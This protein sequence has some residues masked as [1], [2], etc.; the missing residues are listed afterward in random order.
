MDLASALSDR[1]T[2][3]AFQLQFASYR[4]YTFLSGEQN[5]CRDG[6]FLHQKEI[7]QEIDCF[8][9]KHPLDG[10]TVFYL[11]GAGLGHHYRALRAWLH[12]SP[13][14][15]LVIL[16]EDLA[17]IALLMEHSPDLLE[18]SQVLLELF[19][20]D[21]QIDGWIAQ[22]PT[23]RIAV[24]AIA[25]LEGKRFYALRLQILRKAAVAQALMTEALHAHKLLPN[26]LRNIARWPGSFFA[27]DLKGKFRGI[28][29]LI[30]G[31]GPS[32]EA[33]LPLLK[34]LEERA[35]L[36][37][38]GSTL[39]ALTNRGV[40]PHFGLAVDPNKEEFDRLKSASAYEVPLIY[41]SRLQP[42]VLDACSGE[43][44]YLVT[45]TGGPCETYFEKE[46]GIDQVA[47]GPE[48]GTEALSITTLAI[49]FAVE[50]GC[51]PILLC[52]IDLAYTGLRR[53]SGGVMPSSEID[54]HEVKGEV[55][56]PERHL[57]RKDIR[58]KKVHTLVKWVM[59]ADCIADYAKKHPETRFFNVSEGGLGFQGIPNQG[60]REVADREL[61]VQ[62]DLRALVHSA[63]IQCKIPLSGQKISFLI[64][65]VYESL[66]RLLSI[67]EAILE[68]LERIETRL[69]D[70]P[71]GKLA[72]LEI[73]FQEE[74][75]F[76][77][78]FPAL[79]IALNRVV[80]HAL[81]DGTPLQKA[82]LKWK[83]W[84][85]IL[86]EEI[87]IMR[88]SLEAAVISPLDIG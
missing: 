6:K 34:E 7:A 52:G 9:D 79:G 24:G 63:I 59:E 72:I 15:R 64:R 61:T 85:E 3:F 45:H 29:A 12:A 70:Y 77:C 84:H 33:S 83:Q 53:Y 46:M 13:E 43:R 17:V 5:A 44:G 41:A 86:L 23:E 11:Y 10:V 68:E 48:L 57:M 16:E 14:R 30:C 22:F 56:A 39:A 47:V 42:D 26:L 40:H 88:P 65:E 74:K 75:A 54:L 38:G 27:A 28:P 58:G 35:L 76:E 32:L 60:V 81:P 71:T 31:A 2:K 78:L 50:L 18:D 66:V 4:P 62:Q 8:L 69:L 51:N 19:T 21:E 20:S 37:A 36:F 49:A 82:L 1:Y 73:D 55:K 67:A 25:S 87:E 80:A